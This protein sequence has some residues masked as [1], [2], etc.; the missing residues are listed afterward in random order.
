[1]RHHVRMSRKQ[2]EADEL[3]LAVAAILEEARQESGLSYRA[4]EDK[5]D[6]PR[7]RGTRALKGGF[8]GI[9]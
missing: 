9:V 5:A 2:I 4:L 3:S 7:M 6:I 1:M 8:R